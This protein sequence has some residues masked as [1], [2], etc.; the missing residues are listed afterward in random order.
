MW[1]NFAAGS[2][3][4]FSDPLTI[5][6]FVFGVLGGVCWGCFEDIFGGITGGFGDVLEALSRYF[7]RFLEGKNN[8]QITEK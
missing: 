7:G 1:E 4:L 5:A 6:I 8:G 3:A 2:L